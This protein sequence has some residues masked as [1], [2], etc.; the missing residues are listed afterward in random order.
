MKM[1]IRLLTN[2]V[3]SLLTTRKSL[4]REESIAAY[5]LA[6]RLGCEL[7]DWAEALLDESRLK[8][9]G[10]FHPAPIRQKLE[11]HQRRP[12]QLAMLPLGRADVPGLAGGAMTGMRMGPERDWVLQP[13]GQ[14]HY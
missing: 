5:S 3:I 12:P 1:M 2:F 13:S 7:K 11:E 9:E 4:F 6:S 14:C 10:Y 8:R